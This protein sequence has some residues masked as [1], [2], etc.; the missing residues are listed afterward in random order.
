MLKISNRKNVDLMTVKIN[1]K[2]FPPRFK[3]KSLPRKKGEEKT[4]N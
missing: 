1:G 4:K 2:N 3:M